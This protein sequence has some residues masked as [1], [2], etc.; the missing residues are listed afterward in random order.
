M[1]NATPDI[2]PHDTVLHIRDTGQ[3]PADIVSELLGTLDVEESLLAFGTREREAIVSAAAP[4]E[5]E[6]QCPE[7]RRYPPSGDGPGTGCA[8]CAQTGE[9][10]VALR[11]CLVCGNVACC[12]SSPGRHAAAHVRRTGHPVVESAEP[13]ENWRWCYVHQ[14]RG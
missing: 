10:P 9:V 12:D 7:L 8:Q 11:R 4:A 5:H 13:G 6:Q 1:A 2:L 14:R 3:A